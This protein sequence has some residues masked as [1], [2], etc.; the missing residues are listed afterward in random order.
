MTTLTDAYIHVRCLASTH[1]QLPSRLHLRW[2]I[3]L[4][5]FITST[6]HAP[7]PPPPIAGGVGGGG[8]GGGGACPVDVQLHHYHIHIAATDIFMDGFYPNDALMVNTLNCIIV[9]TGTFMEDK[10]TNYCFDISWISVGLPIRNNLL[11]L[12]YLPTKKRPIHSYL[13]CESS[14]MWVSLYTQ[15]RMCV[16]IHRDGPFI[17]IYIYIYIYN[18]IRKC[19]NYV[20]IKRVLKYYVQNKALFESWK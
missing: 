7:P 14:H 4:S 12:R 6:G 5:V 17:Y 2:R 20:C 11:S 1:Q 15:T 10:Q 9:K 3:R 16:H 8:G 19:E 18:C 13:I